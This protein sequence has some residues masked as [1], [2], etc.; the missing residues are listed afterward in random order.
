[1]MRAWLSEREVITMNE[2]KPISDRAWIELADAVREWKSAAL[3][4]LEALQMPEDV[5]RPQADGEQHQPI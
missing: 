2:T 4:V 1:M 3:T 5:G